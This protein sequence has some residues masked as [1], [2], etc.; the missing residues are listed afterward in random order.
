MHGSSV[1][2]F[3][4]CRFSFLQ[5]ETLNLQTWSTCYIV[6]NSQICAY[7]VV[8]WTMWHFLDNFLWQVEQY[9]RRVSRKKA[10][11]EAMLKS[12]MQ[13]QLDGV[14]VGM[15]QLQL[16]LHEIGEIKQKCVAQWAV[17]ADAQYVNQTANFLPSLVIISLCH[18]SKVLTSFTIT[19]LCQGSIPSRWRPSFKPRP[20]RNM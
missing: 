8:A 6:V 17:T 20:V 2:I 11:V 5:T 12:A 16:A 18:T 13:S 9:K 14:R 7:H 1:F 4:F 3:S 10:S 19:M 15:N